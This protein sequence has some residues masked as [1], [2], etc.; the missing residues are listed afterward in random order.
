MSLAFFDALHADPWSE[1][2]VDLAS[3]N[4]NVSDAIEASV[5]HLR[6]VGRREPT[7]LRSTSMVVL[8]PPGAG[9]THLFARLRRRLGPRAVFVHVRPLLH[10]PMTPRFVL[11]EVVRQLGHATQGFRQLDAL[12]GSLLAHV[13]GEGTTFPSA[14]LAMYR[15]LPDVEREERLEAALARVLEL[16]PEADESYLSRLLAAPF[17]SGS[18]QRALLGWLSGRDCDAAQ[19]ERIGASASLPDELAISALRT[20]GV[21]AAIGA[22]L[23]VVFDQLENLIEGAVP[24]S[25]LLGY[26]NLAA[27]LVDAVRGVLLIHMAL[28]TEWDRAIEPSFNLS[29]RSRL[30]GRRALL[31]LP[32][33]REREE[34][35]RLFLE[36]V[37]DRDAPFPWP[38][39]EARLERLCATAGMTPRMLLAEC[40]S[41]L[42]ADPE[43]RDEA[44][45]P[46]ETSLASSEQPSDRFGSSHRDDALA[47]AW[48][49][50]QEAV[51]RRLSEMAEARMPVEAERVLDGLLGAARF[52][53]DAELMPASGQSATQLT[54]IL[55][56]GKVGVALLHQQN[57]KSVGAALS[58]LAALAAREPVIVLRERAR[59]FPPTWRDTIRRQHELLATGRARF[60]LI[61]HEDL[62]RLLALDELLQ[63]ARSGDITDPHG[64]PISED[65]IVRW[66]ESTLEVRSW[67]I[68]DRLLHDEADRAMVSAGADAP[69]EAREEAEIA[70]RPPTAPG[71]GLGVLR[72]LRLAA[73]DRIV[74]EAV[75]MDPATTRASILAELESSRQ[76]RFLGRSIVFFDEGER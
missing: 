18:V 27:E 61:D 8:G 53:V 14:F 23:V 51:R 3:L 28:D 39:D 20:L 19:L 58:R 32:G 30:V 50:R 41:A 15:S 11:G 25:R 42:D 73:L 46:R 63:G 37:P 21:S 72:R 60:L 68:V 69:A 59:D 49:K 31:A 65:T 43:A 66:V 75:R 26:G 2:F 52:L 7:A 44:T 13:V 74:R 36:R 29:Q 12:V 1:D 55:P 24:G 45:P 47:I 4:A 38:F 62:T 70:Q 34:L 33:R 57:P 16:W 6:E 9:K 56:S 40:R 76:A 67:S 35:L 64:R 71:I 5:R 54:L 17:A 10:G 22:P 48:S